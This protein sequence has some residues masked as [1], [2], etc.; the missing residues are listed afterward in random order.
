MARYNTLV[1]STQT[2]HHAAVVN[3]SPLVRAK[4]EI[5]RVLELLVDKMPAEVADLFVEVTLPA[6]PEIN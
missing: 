3:N 1:Q 4:T 2:Q 6:P 5:L